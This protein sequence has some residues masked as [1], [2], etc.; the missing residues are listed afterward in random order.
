MGTIV[1]LSGKETKTV[2]CML[3]KSFPWGALQKTR[4]KYVQVSSSAA[5]LAAH[6]LQEGCP[7]SKIYKADNGTAL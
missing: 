5:I 2:T 1:S 4:N 3:N 7:W 6:G